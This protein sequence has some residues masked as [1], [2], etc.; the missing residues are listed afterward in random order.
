MSI[1]T[2][3][4]LRIEV[5]FASKDLVTNNFPILP[6]KD[7]SVRPELVEGCTEKSGRHRAKPST[8]RQ[9]QHERFGI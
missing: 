4:G 8:L 5:A 9:A 6:D 1:L 7:F 2:T 3:Y